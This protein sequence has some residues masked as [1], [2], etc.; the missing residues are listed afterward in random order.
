MMLLS[1][2][3]LTT[4]ANRLLVFHLLLVLL[5]GLAFVSEVGIN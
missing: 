1:L 5:I 3:S 2:S 4:K